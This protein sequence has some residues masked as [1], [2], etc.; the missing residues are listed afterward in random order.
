MLGEMRSEHFAE[1]SE[2]RGSEAAMGMLYIYIY[3]PA[4]GDDASPRV[5][6]QDQTINMFMCV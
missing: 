6:D 2:I 4:P 1:S 3:A 5:E